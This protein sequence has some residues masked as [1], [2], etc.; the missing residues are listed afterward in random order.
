M[1]DIDDLV[2]IKSTKNKIQINYKINYANKD[3]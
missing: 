1:P 3:S 2:T